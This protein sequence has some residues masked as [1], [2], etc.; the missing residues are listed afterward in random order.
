MHQTHYRLE[1]I[2]VGREPAIDQIDHLSL[3]NTIQS[4]IAEIS[5]HQ[6]EIIL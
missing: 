4:V 2:I 3:R 1:E 5:V 6:S